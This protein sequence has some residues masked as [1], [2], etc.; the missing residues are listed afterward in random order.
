MDEKISM[1][2]KNKTWEVVDL[3][4]RK[5]AISL[6]WIDKTKYNEEGRRPH[7]EVE[8]TIGCKRVPLA[9]R[10]QLQQD[11]CPSCSHGDHQNSLG[12]NRSAQAQGAPTRCQISIPKW[13]ARRRSV[14][15]AVAGLYQR[16]RTQ[17]L[18]PA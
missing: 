5:E 15:R 1:I 12:T 11:I 7:P 13:R 8:G 3:P 17:S 4:E 10:H 6:K 9:V 16:R 18:S 14:H 2:E